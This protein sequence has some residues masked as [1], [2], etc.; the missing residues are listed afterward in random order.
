MILRE[1]DFFGPGSICGLGGKFHLTIHIAH[2]GQ[3][4]PSFASACF[5][6][7]LTFIA[8]RLLNDVTKVGQILGVLLERNVRYLIF[9]IMLKPFFHLYLMFLFR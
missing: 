7:L 1:L 4:H 3:D 2:S 8:N 5:T 9:R 6:E